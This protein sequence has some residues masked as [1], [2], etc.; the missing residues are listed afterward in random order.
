M[1]ER[2]HPRL[3]AQRFRVQ[4]LV[5]VGAIGRVY[6]AIQDPLDRLVALKVL[7]PEMA[8]DAQA[9]RRFFREARA[10][11]RLNHPNVVQVYDFGETDD[12]Q[13]FL[14]MEWVPG[15]SMAEW[16]RNPPALAVLLSSV[17]QLLQGLAAAH[18]RGVLHRDLKPENLMLRGDVAE[19]ERVL[20]SDFGLATVHD[21]SGKTDR[22]DLS[23]GGTPRYMAPE[24]VRQDRPTSPETDIYAV[25]VLLYELLCGRPPFD[26]EEEDV[27]RAHVEEPAPPL[28]PRSGYV[29]DDG[30][31]RIVTRALAKEPE[32]RYRSA[33]EMRSALADVGIG[34]TTS[35]RV[36]EPGVCDEA[37]VGREDELRRLRETAVRTL[38]GPSTSVILLTGTMG[39]GKTT[40]ARVLGADMVQRGFM[41]L[42][43]ARCDEEGL[44]N[45]GFAAVLEEVLGVRGCG[46][47]E[48]RRRLERR[49][50]A[51]ALLAGSELEDI[52]D[53]LRPPLA[54]TLLLDLDES[55]G[56]RASRFARS[57]RGAARS[58]PLMVLLDDLQRASLDDLE[59]LQHVIA[60]DVGDPVPLLI[61]ACLDRDAWSRS[62]PR[63]QLLER[64]TV[65][66]A[67][68]Q[69]IDVGPLGEEACVRLLAERVQAGPEFAAA[70]V[71]QVGTNPRIALAVAELA[72]ASGHTREIEGVHELI[73][74]DALEG[75]VPDDV[76]S[77]VRA[78]IEST[79]QSLPDGQDALRALVAAAVYGEQFDP[80]GAAEL[81]VRAELLQDEGAA[82]RAYERLAGVGLLE[83]RGTPAEDRLAFPTPLLRREVLNLLRD[84]T[85]RRL[86]REAAGLLKRSGRGNRS[87]VCKAI[88]HHLFASGEAEEGRVL[89]Q[90]AA[91]LA[92]NG[93]MLDE[94]RNLYE[95]QLERLG[96]SKGGDAA[97]A[98]LAL[99]RVHVL[100]GNDDEA[101][102]LLVGLPEWADDP[103]AA[104]AAMLLASLA[105]KSGNTSEAGAWLMLA[106]DRTPAD[107][108]AA[109]RLYGE[110]VLLQENLLR[111]RGDLEGRIAHL[112]EAI[113]EL[114][115]GLH[116]VRARRRLAMALARGGRMEQGE[117]L[118]REV[119][120]SLPADAPPWLQVDLVLDRAI[121]KDIQG[122]EEEACAAYAE[123]HE[124]ARDAGDPQR[125]SRALNGLAEIARARGDL[126]RAE[127]MYRDALE[128]ERR[129]GHVRFMSITLVNLCM[130][131][132]ARGDLDEADRVL[133]EVVAVG[134]DVSHP[135]V[136]V[137]YAFARALVA[138]RRGDLDQ[139]R[140]EL[141]RFQA[142]NARVG[143][144]E[145]DIAEALEEL[146]RR[147][148]R[149]GDVPFGNE[150]IEQA[151]LM[152]QQLGRDEQAA[153]TRSR[154]APEG[155]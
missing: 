7:N 66:H 48:A 122:A 17:D 82:L 27:L 4:S 125:I 55:G 37:V 89:L 1:M 72:I 45:A 130:V 114:P 128:I 137:V 36:G 71:A 84:S 61:V 138:G 79:I 28:T 116:R 110:W 151:A 64:V 59:V 126:E 124:R 8:E 5:G 77:L 112:R 31:S 132:L 111:T 52:L 92:E 22:R 143:L 113:D 68:V 81:T 103:L 154:V 93:W 144:H 34:A 123:V 120:G 99:G 33:A 88:A 26:G 145:P 3:I 115:D 147:F 43:R 136:A 47:D 15:G 12:E 38:R 76:R 67:A 129:L 100:Q 25:G 21:V 118:L 60:L 2:T 153:E 98:R 155:G 23:V 44:G 41:S 127:R 142:V 135:E 105:L 42:V 121:V 29:L 101:R 20:I 57:L 49:P 54:D 96:E 69:R 6:Q 74:A 150:L 139:A 58:R 39:A 30:L 107:G 9:R 140:S 109:E 46:R 11:A 16:R 146:G 85:R 56:G 19:P 102:E 53:D 90:R 80:A 78:R 106:R 119:E 149:E 62:D 133:D 75:Q 10:A 94:A 35:I 104:E 73:D 24:Q 97:R 134:A 108:P 95:E 13:L 131:A 87:H 63:A 91:E 32:Q 65:A 14:A 70:V 51:S 117:A 86:H 148:H 50:D 152:W 40:L 141:Y 83:D 18:A